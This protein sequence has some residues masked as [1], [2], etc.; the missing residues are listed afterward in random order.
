MQIIIA[1]ILC[2][3]IT[4]FCGGFYT[5]HEISAAKI[6][7]M[8][9][10]IISANAEAA[11]ILKAET[12]KVALATEAAIQSNLNLDNSHAATINA[13]NSQ[14]DTNLADFSLYTKSRDRCPDPM[15]SGNT[16]GIPEKATREAELDAETDRVI[17]EAAGIA[18]IAA[19]YAAQ[20]YQF[21]A[22][23]NC[24]LKSQ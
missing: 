3:L 7:G 15:P 24:G 13:L 21:A 18:D 10:S 12:D 2:A 20:A 11:A 22:I 6:I 14:H 4:G 23:N 8:E 9:H 17:E 16:T 19:D 1:A 5:A